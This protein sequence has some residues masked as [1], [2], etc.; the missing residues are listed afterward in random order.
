MRRE[1]GYINEIPDR[2]ATD[3]PAENEER[4]EQN[5]LRK[6]GE[7][8]LAPRRRELF[9]T[10]NTVSGFIFVQFVHVL[11]ISLQGTEWVEL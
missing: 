7:K 3:T 5:N 10:R 9:A 6:H 11:A 1:R 8:A 2:S 4:D